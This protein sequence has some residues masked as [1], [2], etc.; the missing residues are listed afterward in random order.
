MSDK[1]E[2]DIKNYLA[3]KN[4]PVVQFKVSNVLDEPTSNR[5]TERRLTSEWINK[6][7][8]TGGFIVGEYWIKKSPNNK[9]YT[10]THLGALSSDDLIELISDILQC[11][12]P[13]IATAIHKTQRKTKELEEQLTNVSKELDNKN[14]I[15]LDKCEKCLE[16]KE[17]C[18]KRTCP[19]W[20]ISP[21]AS[22]RSKT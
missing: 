16:D 2:S 6:Q 12:S 20:I 4:K 19:L 15:I 21:R 8:R 18:R 5:R 7:I 1:F 9:V 22:W 13:H 10:A 3:S 17:I 14:K 11:E